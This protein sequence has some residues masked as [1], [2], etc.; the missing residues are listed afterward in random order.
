MQVPKLVGLE[1][2]LFNFLRL[3]RSFWLPAYN[4]LPEHLLIFTFTLDFALF[5]QVYFLVIFGFL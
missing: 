2:D 4:Y 3:K 5:L 1:C